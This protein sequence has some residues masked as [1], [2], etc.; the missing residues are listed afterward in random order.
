MSSSLAR[1]RQMMK[2][3]HTASHPVYPWPLDQTNRPQLRNKQQ[4]EL[5][6]AIAVNIAPSSQ[7]SPTLL[8][9]ACLVQ[10]YGMAM[11]R[12]LQQHN[13]PFARSDTDQPHSSIQPPCVCQPALRFNLFVHPK[14]QV[15]VGA[16]LLLQCNVNL[17]RLST[18]L[19]SLPSFR[20]HT[21]APLCVQQGS[22][23]EMEGGLSPSVAS[24][25]LLPQC[26]KDAL[27]AV[28]KKLL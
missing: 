11:H 2:F 22:K 26:T 10:V 4:Q 20:T 25:F 14:L 3:D 16:L 27:D 8:P 23:S 18:A 5:C 17:I 7:S 6:T 13:R 19:H 28:Q 1:P 15:G 24:L 12:T 9:A 21:F